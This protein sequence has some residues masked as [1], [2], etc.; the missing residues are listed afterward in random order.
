MHFRTIKTFKRSRFVEEGLSSDYISLFK[1]N[2]VA[3]G[4]RYPRPGMVSKQLVCPLCPTRE[5]NSVMHLALFCQASEHL[6]QTR[7]GITSF[8]NMCQ[9][10]NFTNQK[11]F[12]LFINGEDWNEIPISIELYRER[13]SE[14]FILWNEFN[15][16]W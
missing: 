3:I 10:K 8:R 6:R 11:I 1:Y 12:E 9:A 2:S 16:L 4:N 5:E 13:G 7:T 15:S 14:L